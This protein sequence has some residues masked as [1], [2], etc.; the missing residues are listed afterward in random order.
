MSHFVVTGGSRGIGRALVLAGA[1]AGHRMSFAARDQVALREAQA[2]ADLL[3]P[4]LTRGVVCD[5]SAEREVERLF[6]ESREALGPIDGVVANAGVSRGGILPMTSDE[7]IAA[8]LRT[9]LVGATSTLRLGARAMIDAGRTGTVVVV[10]S[11]AARGTS[12]NAVYAASKAALTSLVRYADAELRASGVRVHLLVP[13]LVDTDLVQ[14]LAPAARERLIACAPLRRAARPEELAALLLE[15][16]LGSGA[17]LAGAP[18]Y[19]TAGLQEI[20]G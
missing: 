2:M 9:N 11:L 18:L 17:V 16:L 14:S 20:P 15:L 12:A 10:G 6:A 1:R 13:G 8:V 4:G 19:A 5:V 3:A 7:D